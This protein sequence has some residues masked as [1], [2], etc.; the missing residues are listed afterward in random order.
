MDKYNR[1]FFLISASSCWGAQI[2]ECEDGPDALRNG[3]SLE[4]LRIKQIPIVE[5]DTIYP[6]I[7]HKEREISLPDALPIII[8][9]NLH[10]AEKVE[11]V[12]KRGFFPVIIGGDHSLAIGTWNGFASHFKQEPFGLI[13]IDAHMDAHTPETSPSGA[14]H[15]MPLA[16]MMGHG[17]LNLSQLLSKDPIL[18]PKNL[19]LVGVR[20]FEEGEAELLKRLGVKV[21]MADEVKKRGV[22]TVL[23][24]AVA[25]VTTHTKKFGISLDMD[26]IDPQEAP[27]VG[28]PEPGGL[29]A[30]ELISALKIIKIDPRLMGF[31]LVEFNPHKDIEKKTFS[32]CQQILEAV[33]SEES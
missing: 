33:L 16:A 31:E 6:L 8:D 13:W 5:W 12:L 19:C 4:K 7:R 11:S 26:V 30:K 28:S 18:L 27:G 24:E 10:L 32:L 20:S 1:H 25:H 22:A 17:E 9:I 3:G 14:W 23:K 29:S 15:G 21:Y 2:R